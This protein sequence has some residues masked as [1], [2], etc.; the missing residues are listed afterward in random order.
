[1]KPGIRVAW[2]TMAV[3][4]PP[5][6]LRW[7]LLATLELGLGDIGGFLADIGV[8]AVVLGALLTCMRLRNSGRVGIGALFDG[9]YWAAVLAWIVANVVSYES[10]RALDALPSIADA[11][12]LVDTTFVWGSGLQSLAAGWVPWIAGA[13]LLLAAFGRRAHVGLGRVLLGTLA[14]GALLAMHGAVG[15]SPSTADWRQTHALVHAF[16]EMTTPASPVPTDTDLA[17]VT[18]GLAADLAGESRVG[19][20]PSAPNVLL[21]L[22]ESIS[23]AYLPQS[24]RAH[25]RVARPTMPGLDAFARDHLSFT[26]FLTHQINTNRGLYAALC[27]DLPKLLSGTPKM[28]VHAGRGLDTCL[29][30]ILRDAGYRTAY[31]QAAPLA[32]M[33]KDQFMPRIGFDQVIGASGFPDAHARSAWGVDDGTLF[34]RATS[35]VAELREGDGPWFATLLTVGTH[36]PYLVPGDFAPGEADEFTRAVAY[37][38]REVTRFLADIEAAGVLE[39]TLVL[40]T[41]DESR[42]LR[43]LERGAGG[44]DGSE[45][46]YE[47]SQLISQS[48]GFLVAAGPGIGTGVVDRPFA[49]SDLPLSV[50]D[51]L[52]MEEAAR[53][54][55][56]LG[57]SVFRSSPSARYVFFGNSRRHAVGA[58]DPEGR[59]LL[60]RRRFRHCEAFDTSGGIFSPHRRPVPW[61]ADGGGGGIVAAVANW[62]LTSGVPI[63]PVGTFELMAEHR[64]EV[65]NDFGMLHGG[66]NVE[67]RAGEWLEVELSFFVERLLEGRTES[68]E[69]VELRHLLRD[70][71][72]VHL[73]ELRRVPAGGRYALRYTFVPEKPI[74]KIQ[75]MSMARRAGGGSKL[76][77]GVTMALDFETARLHIRSGGTR[78]AP[79]L[80]ILRDE[81]L[82]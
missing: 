38:D 33:L 18:R 20:T 48:W 11:G 63:E 22:V 47:V 37:A 54:A 81:T 41:S 25:G 40:V 72:R 10:V 24:A 30:G 51:Y 80:H 79:G 28:S 3:L 50:L 65:G 73:D 82:P 9:V 26:S 42:G 49:T 70:P 12:Y 67:L 32:F 46:E 7:H 74:E 29:P 8:S 56:L 62:S 75:S 16:G 78:P 57:R 76:A 61:E 55:G 43:G 27:G 1:V 64:V 14:G 31:L 17:E 77:P 19:A 4:L 6:A 71:L 23:G 53:S 45:E 68:S 13:S 36:H 44:G 52:G 21:V 60:C 66:Q 35:L 58:I 69:A 2:V 59:L 34:E 5:L 15:W 39:N